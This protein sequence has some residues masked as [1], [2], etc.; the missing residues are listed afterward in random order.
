MLIRP[1]VAIISLVEV[2]SSLGN[3]LVVIGGYSY[4]L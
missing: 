4:L 1:V 2:L 3:E